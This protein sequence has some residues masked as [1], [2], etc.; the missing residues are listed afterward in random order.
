MADD[1]TRDPFV[2][3]VHKALNRP[4]L[5]FG[6]V[7]RR[8]FFAAF[9]VG[10]VA[11]SVT[12]VLGWPSIV[13]LLVWVAVVGVLCIPAYLATKRDPEM[14]GIAWSAYWRPKRYDAAAHRPFELE[15]R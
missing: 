9:G 12:W 8:M 5:M 13:A 15:I 4:L 7:E 11:G 10:G 2:H 14:L 6:M 3:P 1:P